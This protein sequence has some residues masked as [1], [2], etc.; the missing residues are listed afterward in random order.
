MIEIAA[1]VVGILSALFLPVALYPF[2][3]RLGVVDIPNSRSSHQV[4]TIRG[5]GLS[6]AIGGV[7]SLCLLSAV[8]P[9]LTD[10]ITGVAI[11]ATAA[12]ALGF[13]EDVRG[14][15]TGK[16]A[17]LQLLIGLAF[18]VY[19]VSIANISWVLVPVLA[20]VVAGYVNVANF[21]D[22]IDGISGM[23]GGVVGIVYAII[24]W[25]IG[26][27][28]MVYLGM[29]ACGIFLAFLPWNISGKR[30]FLGDVGS[31]FL[32]AWISGM[33]VMAIVSGI[34]WIAVAGPLAIYLA[35]TGTTLFGRIRRGERWFEAHRTHVYQRLATAT[36][37]HVLVAGIVSV[38][39]AA[40][41]AAS[42]LALVDGWIPSVLSVALL[43]V[44]VGTYL[45]LPSFL[46]QRVTATA[47]GV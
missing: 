22:G 8:A 11:V 18:G 43:F 34:N 28:W 40:A 14:V 1:I 2:L 46:A 30:V 6:T 27:G 37:S 29:L 36:R 41:G 26:A 35:D 17:L 47:S 31:Y 9:E 5:M 19:V 21:M 23:H 24:G 39:T 10:M 15:A 42:M 32:G 3:D 13:V 38:F 4:P 25:W 33:A 20:F 12:A 44:V 16:R 45:C 7:I